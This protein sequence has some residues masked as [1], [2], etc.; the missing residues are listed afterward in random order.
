MSIGS[1]NHDDASR[2]LRVACATFFDPGAAQES[3]LLRQPYGIEELENRGLS[4]V[5]VPVNWGSRRPLR[6][7]QA[8]RQVRT[9]AGAA[10]VVFAMFESQA[11]PI[12]LARALH[13]PGLR[14][15]PLVVLS[16]WLGEEVLKAGPSRL[17]LLQ[18]SYRAVD[19]LLYFSSN[20]QE[21]FASRLRV[22]SSRLMAIPYGVD[23]SWF[24]SADVTDDGYI[25]SVGRDRGRDWQCLFDAVRGS[26]LDVRIACRPSEIDHFDVPAEVTVEG[27][28]SR[29]RYRE[30]L[31][32]A[33]AVVLPTHPRA[34][35]TGQSV[36]LEAMA[37][38]KCVI[39]SR[40]AALSDYLDDN[41]TAMLVPV[42]DS[43]SLR[44][45]MRDVISRAELRSRIGAAAQRA[46][47][48]RFR[49][50]HMWAS[51]AQV[52]IAEAGRR[53]RRQ[54]GMSRS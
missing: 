53:K 46:V 44:I 21:I 26:G 9:F 27:F 7:L 18:L 20:Q 4:L 3:G 33:T 15:V 1:V 37:M 51:V 2:G 19:R 13:L 17:R 36:A 23:F 14:R 28:V 48:S 49:A 50:Q 11:N 31:S 24:E 29:E 40:T 5:H 32:R 10:D 22:P 54:Q 42:G 47:A 38:G 8:V 52:L 30:M 6:D 34:Y 43:A 41:E 25:V 45:A 35:P 39:A 12:A 16:C